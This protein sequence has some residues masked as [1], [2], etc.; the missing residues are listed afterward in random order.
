MNIFQHL[1]DKR[2]DLVDK[3][4]QDNSD[5]ISKIIIRNE[6]NQPKLTIEKK[7]F[8]LHDKHDEFFNHN[9]RQVRTDEYDLI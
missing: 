6:D 5:E 2:D 3:I 7:G 8:N 4:K 1:S 9:T